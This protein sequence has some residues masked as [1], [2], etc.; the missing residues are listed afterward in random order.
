MPL[1]RRTKKEVIRV[2]TNCYDFVAA[3]RDEFVSPSAEIFISAP[4]GTRYDAYSPE[5]ALTAKESARYHDWQINALADL[6]IDTLLFT[7]MSG[8]PEALGCAQVAAKT[9]APYLVSFIL[10]SEGR[11]LDGSSLH[12]AIDKIDM[13]V[14]D[15]PPLAYLILCT[16]PS[17]AIETFAN[18]KP[19]YSR[20]KGIKANA[21]RSSTVALSSVQEA[22][23][24]ESPDEFVQ[25]LA[26]LTKQYDWRIVGGCCG[27]S[28][29]HLAKLADKLVH[30]TL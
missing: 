6:G 2:N 12:D 28:R 14:S 27:T 1:G 16:H 25:M 13:T 3:I 29:I 19:Q 26:N 20:I 22:L 21:S 10:Q 17:V 5:L 15:N 30:F 9:K 4:V 7:S 11:L 23:L 8:F 24:D 18:F